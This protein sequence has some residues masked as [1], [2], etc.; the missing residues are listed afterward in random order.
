[1]TYPDGRFQFGGITAPIYNNR[2]GARTPAYHRLDI[3]CYFALVDPSLHDYELDLA[4][5]A[6]NLYA[7][8]N[9]YSIYFQANSDDPTI[10]EAYRLSIYGT[11]IPYI[12]LN[13]N[14]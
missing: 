10:T 13:F 2:N 11:I 1:I 12:T 5:G 4:I 14:F 8:K 7:R 9:P 6:Y 3:S